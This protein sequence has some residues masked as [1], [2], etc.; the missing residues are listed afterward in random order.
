M[1]SDRLCDQAFDLR[2]DRAFLIGAVQRLCPHHL[3]SHKARINQLPYL[4]LNRP[5]CY[6]RPAGELTQVEG[7]AYVA[8]QYGKHGPSSSSE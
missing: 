2:E 1:H 7:F 6:F 3:S 4:A 8:V 5:E